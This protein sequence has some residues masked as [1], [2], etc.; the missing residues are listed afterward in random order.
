MKLFQKNDVSIIKRIAKLLFNSNDIKNLNVESLSENK[1]HLL[2]KSFEKILDH[3][4]D[5]LNK[6]RLCFIIL[7]NIGYNNEKL[8]EKILNPNSY[9]FFFLLL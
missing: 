9:N 5:N 4:I 2:A 8:M 3:K 6:S 1:I 7:D